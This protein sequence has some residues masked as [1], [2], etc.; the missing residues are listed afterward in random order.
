M[1]QEPEIDYRFS[2][3]ICRVELTGFESHR[4]GLVRFVNKLR[5]TTEGIQSSNYLGWHSDRNLHV[6]PND[7][8]M[9]WLVKKISIKTVQLLQRITGAETGVDVR[10]R[11]LWANINDS[12]GWNVPHVHPVSWAGVVYVTGSTVTEDPGETEAARPGGG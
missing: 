6:E 1:S 8:D 7:P 5:E 12:G 2:T 10:L 3:P 9:Q 4:D 11:E